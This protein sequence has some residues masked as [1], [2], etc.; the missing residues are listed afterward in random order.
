[1]LAKNEVFRFTTINGYLITKHHFCFRDLYC[2]YRLFPICCTF[3]LIC[4]I[5]LR[6]QILLIRNKTG[7]FIC[8]NFTIKPEPVKGS[9]KNLGE[10]FY[11][12]FFKERSNYVLID[13]LQLFEELFLQNYCSIIEI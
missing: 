6:R 7:F 4:P 5:L 2:F 11:N 13:N 8:F 3:T 12:D 10:N 9:F 1:M